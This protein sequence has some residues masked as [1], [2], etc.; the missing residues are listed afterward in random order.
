MPVVLAWVCF[1]NLMTTFFVFWLDHPY[2]LWQTKY[3]FYQLSTKFYFQSLSMDCFL[4]MWDVSSVSAYKYSSD[5]SIIT[6]VLHLSLFCFRERNPFLRGDNK[7]GPDRCLL[8]YWWLPAVSPALASVR[9]PFCLV[10]PRLP[11]VQAVI[12]LSLHLVLLSPS[13]LANGRT[14]EACFL[15]LNPPISEE[16]LSQ[17]R[18]VFP[19]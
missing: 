5:L 6:T 14:A 18:G 8:S 16:L 11:S 1:T 9:Q 19:S 7:C 2:W 4:D 17:T 10:V 15:P 12:L 3:S 13:V